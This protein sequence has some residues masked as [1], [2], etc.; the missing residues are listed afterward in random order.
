MGAACSNSDDRENEAGNTL[1]PVEENK[2]KKATQSNEPSLGAT[3]LSEDIK[4]DHS[5]MSP[6][7]QHSNAKNFEACDKM[8]D[9]HPNVQKRYE[10]LKPIKGTDF[11]YLYK[12]Y[13]N[14]KSKTQIVRDKTTLE[15]YEG[16]LSKG[17]PH[18][19]G[20]LVS[21]EGDL[22]EGYFEEGKSVGF[23]RRITAPH[24][25]CYN[26]QFKDGEPY[27]KGF[28]IDDKGYKTEC[29][30]WKQGKTNGKT[31]IKNAEG[32]ELFV[33]ETKEG[34]K[35]GEGLLKDDKDNCEYKG[36][37]QDGLLEGQGEKKW[38][39]GQLYKGLFVK[40]VE[41]GKGMLTFVDGRKFVGTF[42]NGK[43]HGQGTLI[44]DN[45]KTASVHFKDGKRV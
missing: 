3:K 34:I 9:I 10:D 42:V 8:N 23:V 14:P 30:T 32:V 13:C 5:P 22:L 27:A 44:T 29:D 21:L 26:G 17:V 40:G 36:T 18:G 11:A 39:N 37:F 45:G 16:D 4:K 35:Q 12:K 2:L 1:S 15:T 7:N 31:V 28:S 19:W 33:G 41:E 20:R 38:A 43:P 6:V 25:A 24:G